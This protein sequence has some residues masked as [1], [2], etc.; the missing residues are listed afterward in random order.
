MPLPTMS[1]LHCSVLT[2]R[3]TARLTMRPIGIEDDCEKQRDHDRDRFQR[4]LPFKGSE[5]VIY[6]EH[7]T[8]CDPKAVDD[9]VQ[10]GER[11]LQQLAWG[12]RVEVVECKGSHYHDEKG[13]AE[14]DVCEQRRA[15][16]TVSWLMNDLQRSR[17]AQRQC[18]QRPKLRARV[19]V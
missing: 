3:N 17:E 15:H 19:A 14:R 2:A 11:A 8:A 12:L 5:E 13:Q 7:D 1:T 6:A 16:R 10:F 9:V 4:R 18:N